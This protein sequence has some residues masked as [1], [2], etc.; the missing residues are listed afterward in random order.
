M[1]FFRGLGACW[2]DWGVLLV[3]L[4]SRGGAASIIFPSIRVL[5]L[6]IVVLGGVI[7][8]SEPL[9]LRLALGWVLSLT[10]VYLLLLS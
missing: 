5:S 4:L 2:W 8:L 1:L 3:N 6:T 9:N 7:L 10:G